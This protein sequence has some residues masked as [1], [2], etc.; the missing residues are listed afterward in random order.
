VVARAGGGTAATGLVVLLAP[1]GLGTVL[2]C[3]VALPLGALAAAWLFARRGSPAAAGLLAGLAVSLDHRAALLAPLLL[4]PL[5]RRTAALRAVLAW[6]LGTYAAVVGPIAL[7]DVPAYAS[8]VLSISRPGP[9]LGIF[10]LLA[11]WGVEGSTVALA[12]AALAPLA[13]LAVALALVRRS[14][15]PLALAGLAA[16]SGL[17]LAP[18]VAPDM[19][20]VPIALLTLSAIVPETWGPLAVPGAPSGAEGT[21]RVASSA[22]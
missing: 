11:Y 14:P 21:S 8:R 9:G 17:A 22:C 10:N 5:G 13:A 6:G 18:A 4:L 19:V 1:L 2:G 7:L 16:L 3:A 12:L 15:P 20:A